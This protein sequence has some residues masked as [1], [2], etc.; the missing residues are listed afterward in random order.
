MK[1]KKA[2]LHI[3]DRIFLWEGEP[4]QIIISDN[5]HISC[6]CAGSQSNAAH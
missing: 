3:Q 6:S 2:Y 1:V 5:S 4:R